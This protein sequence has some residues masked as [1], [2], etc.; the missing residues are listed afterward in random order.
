MFEENTSVGL[1]AATSE[2]KWFKTDG[3]ISTFQHSSA[4]PIIVPDRKNTRFDKDP[5]KASYISRIVTFLGARHKRSKL[6]FV[7][8]RVRVSVSQVMGPGLRICALS[9]LL[10]RFGDTPKLG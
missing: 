5:L 1:I 2:E 7:N 10:C 8:V 3:E 6:L 4:K 9:G